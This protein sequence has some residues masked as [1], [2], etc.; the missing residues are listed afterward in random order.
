M[1]PSPDASITTPFVY[2]KAHNSYLEF[3]LEAGVPALVLMIGVLGGLTALSAHGIW[4]HREN[5]LFPCIGV[6]AAALVASHAVIDFSL[7]IPAVAVI[8]AV[9][10]GIATAQ[11]LRRRRRHDPGLD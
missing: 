2:D 5:R 11:S 8:F 6:A 10:L 1:C 9:L 4:K 7:Q 3:A